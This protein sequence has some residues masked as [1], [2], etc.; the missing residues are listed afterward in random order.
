[1]KS[2]PRSWGR[3]GQRS[4][5]SRGGRPRTITPP[6]AGTPAGCSTTGPSP[7]SD[8]LRVEAPRSGHE[9]APTVE[10]AAVEV[11]DR[12]VDVLQRVLLGVELDLAPGRQGHEL[13]EVHV[14]PHEVADDVDLADDEVPVGDVDPLAVA[15]HVVGAALA[16]HAGDLG[17]HAPPPH[18]VQDRIGADTAGQLHDPVDDALAGLDHMVGARLLGQLPGSF[19]GVGGDDLDRGQRPQT[20]D[21]DMAKAADAHDD[22][23]GLGGRIAGH[24]L[25]GPHGGDAG[26]GHG[27]H[28]LGL[29]ARVELDERALAGQ[30]VLSEAPVH[31]EA[32]EGAVV[33][34]HVL[35][36]AAAEAHATAHQRVHD[37]GVAGADRRHVGAHL[38]DPPGVLVAEGVRQLE[39]GE[40]LAQDAL[41]D[42]E[43][44]PAE[45]G[46][47][48]LDD[49]VLGAA[50]LRFRDVVDPETV[51]VVAVQAGGVHTD[52]SSS[53]GSVS[54]YLAA[55]RPRQKLAFPSMLTLTVRAKIRCRSRVSSVMAF[56]SRST[57]NGAPSAVSSPTRARRSR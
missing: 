9:D 14:V 18:E 53:F 50:D 21:A 48:D 52:A 49:D 45:A 32:G 13:Y 16:Q 54:P 5:P 3:P 8:R 20:L 1:M 11:V 43:V 4:T 26:V 12:L 40:R 56:P 15:D 28:V 51:V 38:F 55:S 57:R 46:P 6:S 42:V 19:V 23:A 34:V 17:G 2:A 36:A 39:V 10:A 30:K 47:A 35:A 44:G 25:A 22:H 41:D 33:A 7:V 29:E 24:L 27:R 31:A 37:H